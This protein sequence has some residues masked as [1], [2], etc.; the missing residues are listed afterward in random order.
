MHEQRSIARTKIT[1]GALLFFTGQTGVRSCGV[2]DITRACTHKS[3]FVSELDP[4]PLFGVLQT[5]TGHRLRSE[6]CQQATSV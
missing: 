2:M 1:K 3:R 4:C 5:Q 6:K